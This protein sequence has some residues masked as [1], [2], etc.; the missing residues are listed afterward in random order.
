MDYVVREIED[1]RKIVEADPSQS[2][3]RFNVPVETHDPLRG[4]VLL[5]LD[6]NVPVKELFGG[7]VGELFEKL[8]GDG[9]FYDWFALRTEPGATRQLIHYDTPHSESLFCIFIALQDVEFPMGPTVFLPGTHANTNERQQFD[10]G[11]TLGMLNDFDEPEYAHLKAGDGAFFDMGCLHAVMSNLGP[12]PRKL[13]V[14]TFR[15]EDSEHRT[16]AALGHKS[17]MRPDYVGKLN[18]RHVRAESKGASLFI[19]TGDELP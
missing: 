13:L 7:I 17:N 14:V 15:K 10:A 8:C 16:V 2:L 5:P 4:Y 19:A 9:L 11:A 3:S 18:L 6:D 12:D 1:S